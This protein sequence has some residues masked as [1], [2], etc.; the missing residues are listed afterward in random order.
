MALSQ[1]GAGYLSRSEIRDPA[2]KRALDDVSSQ[3]KAIGRQVNAEPGGITP[4]PPQ[5]NALSVT[6]ADGIFDAQIQDN[7]PVQRGVVYFLEYSLNATGPWSLIAIGPARNWRGA[8]GNQTFFWRAYSQY[9]TSD[10]SAPIY[11][12]G[13]INPTGVA[14]GGAA[15][16]APQPPAGSGTDPSNN[17][18][19]GGGGFGKQKTRGFVDR[20]R[21]TEL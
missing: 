21:G 1:K 9:P 2:I 15:G 7:N 3:V 20:L 13:P 17:R 10:P 6:A 12:G 5:I 18:G 19:P 16:P 4:A 14:G 11:F 8:L